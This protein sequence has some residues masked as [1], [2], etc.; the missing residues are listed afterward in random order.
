M[1]KVDIDKSI[2][3]KKILKVFQSANKK[4]DFGEF[5]KNLNK[6][7]ILNDIKGLDESNKLK[8]LMEYWNNKRGKLKVCPIRGKSIHSQKIR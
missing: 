2:H 5:V 8:I 7:N 1:S 4:N 6:L 3:S